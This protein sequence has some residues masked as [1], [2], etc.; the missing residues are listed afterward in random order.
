MTDLEFETSL[1]RTFGNRLDS[2]VVAIAAPVE[3]Y[4]LDAEF[5]CLLGHYLA[6][7]FSDLR[8][9]AFRLDQFLGQ[10][11]GRCQHPCLAVIHEQGID[12]LTA[13]PDAQSWLVGTADHSLA[14]PVAPSQEPISNHSGNHTERGT[15]VKP[16]YP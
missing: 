2:T 7:L 12:M 1:S 16:K 4:L 13:S 6:Y 9:R 11:R 15:K 8:L 10:R 14:N 5:L 3:D